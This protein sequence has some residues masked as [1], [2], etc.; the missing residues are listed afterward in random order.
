MSFFAKKHTKVSINCETAYPFRFFNLALTHF[1]LR[2]LLVDNEQTTF[3][4]NN[5][6]V[7]CTLL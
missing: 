4:T 5:L 7:C 2:V 6:A 1:E 3:T